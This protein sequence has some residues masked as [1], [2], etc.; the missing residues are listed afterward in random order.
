MMETILAEMG[1]SDICECE[2]GAEP[3]GVGGCESCG[4]GTTQDWLGEECDDSNTTD[5]DGCSSWCMN[6]S[7]EC[8]T[9]LDIHD[10][11]LVSG[12]YN[13]IN[14][15]TAD[16]LYAD[17]PSGSWMFLDKATNWFIPI[18]TSV[19]IVA[20]TIAWDP[21]YLRIGLND[22][23]TPFNQIVSGT[24][25]SYQ[26]STWRQTYTYVMP[27]SSRAFTVYA[28][29][30]VVH[31]DVLYTCTCTGTLPANSEICNGQWSGLT[32]S[33]ALQLVSSCTPWNKCEYTC[34][35]GYVYNGWSCD[36]ISTV[37]FNPTYA[38]GSFGG[39]MEEISNVVLWHQ[40][41]GDLNSDN[42]DDSIR[43]TMWFPNITSWLF[44]SV[45]IL[46]LHPNGGI[47]GEIQISEAIEEDELVAGSRDN[48]PVATVDDVTDTDGDTNPNFAFALYY[49]EGW[50]DHGSASSFHAYDKMDC[51]DLTPPVCSSTLG[52]CDTGNPSNDS[53]NACGTARTWTCTNDGLP[54][55]CNGQNAPCPINGVCST[56]TYNTCVA[57]IAT[58]AN[59]TAC[60]TNDTWTCLGQYGGNNSGT[61]SVAD[62][63]PTCGSTIGQCGVGSA[64]NQNNTACWT[65]DTWDC[66][67][68][69]T[70][71]LVHTQ[72]CI[73]T[74]PCPVNGAC[75]G[76]FNTCAL[77]TPINP[78]NTACDT[79]DTWTC[80]GLNGGT[81]DPCTDPDPCGWGCCTPANS[82]NRD[83]DGSC[84]CGGAYSRDDNDCWWWSS[85]SSP[86]CNEE[87]SDNSLPSCSGGETHRIYTFQRASPNATCSTIT[88]D[89][90]CVSCNA[91]GWG[92]CKENWSSVT[93]EGNE[94][95][96]LDGGG[97]RD[98]PSQQNCI[99]DA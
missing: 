38:S 6:E 62:P 24:E 65:N 77:G 83:N 76:T 55:W 96:T 70:P 8:L 47:M 25:Q 66:V 18:S 15:M 67:T 57:G 31:L 14:T 42:R 5:G 22:L 19:S 10:D 26:L 64:A 87:Y 72:G 95:C 80:E 37:C 48:S 81:N 82:C 51:Q 16:G 91:S 32:W 75:G 84:D 40:A 43:G 44:P 89:T 21:W 46:Y 94:T 49:D 88:P 71:N 73:D 23:W 36:D 35:W 11:D 78:V 69:W 4:D 27:A 1:C 79:D 98:C 97:R 7:S 60:A 90:M 20:R 68:S 12:H 58:G 61:C 29:T 86:D 2:N 39:T 50:S 41:A 3:D 93:Y 52:A 30:W 63:C 74:E 53:G 54:L 13:V 45:S 59:D 85:C 33:I 17:I 34:Q 99:E 92:T 9:I 56:L 28:D